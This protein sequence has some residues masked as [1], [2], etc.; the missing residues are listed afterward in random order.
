MSAEEKQKE[1]VECENCFRKFPKVDDF[2]YCPKCRTI[3]RIAIKLLN[4][5]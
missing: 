1:L 2:P 5:K 3:P 4:Q